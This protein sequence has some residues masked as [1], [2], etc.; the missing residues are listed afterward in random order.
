MNNHVNYEFVHK[1]NLKIA[2][3]DVICMSYIAMYIANKTNIFKFWPKVSKKFNKYLISNQVSK[4]LSTHMENIFQ[5]LSSK[6][7]IQNKLTTI[8]N[9]KVRW[10]L[11][12]KGHTITTWKKKKKK[13]LKTS[14]KPK[15]YPK[16]KKTQKFIPPQKKNPKIYV[17][18]EFHSWCNPQC[19]VEVRS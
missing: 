19:Y 18:V 9:P 3:Y 7:K 2:S 4:Y 17:L 16:K 14:S 10:I 1:K 12:I 13:T 11:R 5:L 8:W 6:F 15:I